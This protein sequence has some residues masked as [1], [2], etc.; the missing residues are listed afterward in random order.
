MKIMNGEDT[1]GQLIKY[2]SDLNH[3]VKALK[4]KNAELRK[5]RNEQEAKVKERTAA[6]VAA[7]KNL[8]M[9]MR[10]RQ[11]ALEKNEELIEKLHHALEDVRVLSGLIPICAH[12]K[13]IRDDEGFW[14][15]IE[16]YL[17]AMT[18]A[19]FSHG[20]CPDCLEKHYPDF[21]SG[22]INP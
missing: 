4:Q 9:Q 16:D 22:S 15:R 1:H 18:P 20:I 2:A 10:L 17:Q 8:E 12:C 5:A 6:L 13:N 21:D 3:Q 14:C 19:Q 7:N 11:M